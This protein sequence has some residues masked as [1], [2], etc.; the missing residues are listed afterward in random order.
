MRKEKKSKNIGRRVL[1]MKLGIMGTITGSFDIM[2]ELEIHVV[3]DGGKGDS[4]YDDIWDDVS[5]GDGVK[6]PLKLVADDYVPNYG[7]KRKRMVALLGAIDGNTDEVTPEWT[8][9]TPTRE[10]F[11]H[12]FIF[13]EKWTEKRFI[14]TAELF[15]REAKWTS[16]MRKSPAAALKSLRSVII[17]AL[18]SQLKDANA[19]SIGK[20]SKGRARP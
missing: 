17:E 20:P 2:R 16:S 13:I 12:D 7:D 5:A 3:W 14:A 15:G 8:K 4:G 6:T 18:D 9:K 11:G 1:Y 19:M 10:S